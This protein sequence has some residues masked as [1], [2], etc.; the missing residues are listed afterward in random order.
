MRTRYWFLLLALLLGFAGAAA[1]VYFYTEP[2]LAGTKPV[3]TS[4][5]QTPAVPRPASVP[6]W[7]WL[8]LVLTG[9]G[10]CLGATYYLRRTGA[11]GGSGRRT[12][13]DKV[14]FEDKPTSAQKAMPGETQPHANNFELHPVPGD[15][16]CQ[17]GA[18]AFAQWGN[19][20][21]WRS[22][23]KLLLKKMQQYAEEDPEFLRACILRFEE[24]RAELEA[25]GELMPDLDAGDRAAPG[26]GVETYEQRRQRYLDMLSRNIDRLRPDKKWGNMATLATFKRLFQK[27]VWLFSE[28]KWFDPDSETESKAPD[29][30]NQDEVHLVYSNGNHYDGVV[31]V[32]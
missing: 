28:R 31:W 3:P 15:G 11:G 30:N 19:K 27:R 2:F 21:E 23:K 13:T 6:G 25:R 22:M 32:K 12:K 24:N 14:A 20:D 26:G 29:P 10:A 5:V 17:Y 16:N 18:L 1:G 4:A 8:L 9:L 7:P